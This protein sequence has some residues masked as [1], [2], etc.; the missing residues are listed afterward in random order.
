AIVAGAVARDTGRGRQTVAAMG[1]LL[2]ALIALMA[3]HGN[4]PALAADGL[5]PGVPVLAWAKGKRVHFEA[6]ATSTRRAADPR[7]DR[8]LRGVADTAASPLS[9]STPRLQYWGGTVQ[10][11]PHLMLVFLGEEWESGS[12]LS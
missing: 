12:D 7:D 2:A 8:A 9:S 5:P 3:V 4:C 10:N 11:E 1:A 6:A